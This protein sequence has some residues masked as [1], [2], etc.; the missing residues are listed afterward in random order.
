VEKHLFK[1]GSSSLG[2]IMPK[3]WVEKRGLKASSVI[4]LVENEGGDIVIKTA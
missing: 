1:F 4:Y 3:K 2:L